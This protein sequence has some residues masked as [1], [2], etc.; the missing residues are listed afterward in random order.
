[1][2]QGAVTAT[3]IAVESGKVFVA[4]YVARTWNGTGWLLRIVLSGVV[5]ML[6]LLG[7]WR[8]LFRCD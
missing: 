2:R 5:V 1:M 7:K 6:S 4:G 8:R 3:G